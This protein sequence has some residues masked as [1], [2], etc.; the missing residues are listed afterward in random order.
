MCK[1]DFDTCSVTQSLL[2]SLIAALECCS[3]RKSRR[4]CRDVELEW[5]SREDVYWA[6]RLKKD[7][8]WR[9]HILSYVSRTL[10]QVQK[11]DWLLLKKNAKKKHRRAIIRTLFTARTSRCKR[12]MSR[13]Y[14]ST[15]ISCWTE[16]RMSTWKIA[17]LLTRHVLTRGASYARADFPYIIIIIITVTNVITILYYVRRTKR[18]KSIYRNRDGLQSG[19][20]VKQWIRIRSR[21]DKVI[22]LRAR[23]S[24]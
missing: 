23:C 24:V 16:K 1:D 11:N 13:N 18:E 7:T 17:H 6:I 4:V 2:S 12:G 3:G 8:W 9:A 14:H 19:H 20:T 21:L 15:E 5:P 22:F 10:K